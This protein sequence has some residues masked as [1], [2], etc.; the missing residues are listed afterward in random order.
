MMVLVPRK[1]D[2]KDLLLLLK[3]NHISNIEELDKQEQLK[4]ISAKYVR[5]YQYLQNLNEW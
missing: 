5:T 4:F 2:K 1:T 3:V